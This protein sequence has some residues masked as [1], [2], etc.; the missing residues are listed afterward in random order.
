[1]PPTPAQIQ[2]VQPGL[3][4]ILGPRPDARVAQP[5][6][7]PVGGRR[8]DPDQLGDHI[9]CL[10][11]A[12]RGLTGS[13]EAAEDLVQDTYVR[14]LARPRFLRRDDDLGYLLRTLRNT[15]LS[16]RR[17]AQRRPITQPLDATAEPTDERDEWRPERAAETQIVYA[18]IAE[19]SDDFRDA[20]VAVDVVGLSYRQAARALRVREA[21]LTTRLFRARQR[22]AQRLGQGDPMTPYPG[23]GRA[24]TPTNEE[25]IHACIRF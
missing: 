17:T 5:A 2:A 21:T 22:V 1:L 18:A 24:K 11:R 12:A 6:A 16:S 15:F 7:C 8:L 4:P 23:A 14:V 13:R 9:D 25:P 20:L 10:Y 3:P 19:L